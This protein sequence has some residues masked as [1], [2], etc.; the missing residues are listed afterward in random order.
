MAEPVF[1]DEVFGGEFAEGAE[2]LGAVGGHPDEV[3]GGDGVPAV[4]EAVDA[5]ALEHEEAVLHVVDF[6]DGE[7]GT[8]VV[9]HGVDGEVPGGAVGH[10]VFDLE[11]GVVVE[12]LGGDLGFV[13]G[14]DC[15]ERGGGGLIG[16][17]D[18]D[19][20]GGLGCGEGVG[21]VGG[22]VGEVARGEDG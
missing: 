10:E 11:G 5:A 20:F 2:P 9:G 13:A 14:E 22:E 21:G 7:G 4:A 6:D 16:F 17:F 19:G 8:G 18:E 15:G 3:A 1:V 12:G